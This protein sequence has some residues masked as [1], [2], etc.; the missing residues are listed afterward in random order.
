M[1][2]A[3]I[4]NILGRLNSFECKQVQC[5]SSHKLILAALKPIR[6][7]HTVNDDLLVKFCL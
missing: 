5:E 4:S 2:F 6:H 1:V 3:N 7:I